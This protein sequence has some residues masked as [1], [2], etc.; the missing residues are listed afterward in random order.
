MSSRLL[1]LLAPLHAREAR[2][3]VGVPALLA[4]TI[5]AFYLLAAGTQPWH[6]RLGEGLYLLAGAGVAASVW[7]ARRSSPS[8]RV[9]LAR[10]WVDLLI[11]GGCI[12]SLA[13]RQGRW[14]SVEWTLHLSLAAAIASRLGFSMFARLAPAR[15]MVIVLIGGATMAL[16][17]VGFYALEPSVSSYAD[18]LWLA[19]TSGATVGYGD[20]VPTAPAARVFAVFT[21]LL[22]YGLLSIVTGAI[23]ATLI[24]EEERGFQ[25]ELHQ[26]IRALR[27]EV[28]SLRREIHALR[29][30]RRGTT[31]EYVE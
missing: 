6:W 13:G 19:F 26:D 20:L 8:L 28:S 11:A 23:A 16:A 25:R 3:Q 22:G 9:L 18:G 31:T 4:L 5:P 7:L 17:G 10:R 12:A 27:R 30:E 2:Q 29:D 14:S 15:V 21:V 24:G 1:D